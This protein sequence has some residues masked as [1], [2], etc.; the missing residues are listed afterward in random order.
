MTALLKIRDEFLS[1]KKQDDRADTAPVDLRLV[2]EKVSPREI[3]RQRVFAEVAE[4]NE[5]RIANAKAHLRTRSFL[6]QVE[7]NSPEARL[8]L[9]LPGRPRSSLLDAETEFAKALKGFTSNRFIMLFDDR[10]V[11]GLEDDLTVMPG[12]EVTFVHLTPLKGG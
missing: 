6:I 4:I 2:S 7:D 11:D 10:Q 8:N 5:Q 12:S 3:I 1:A 9:P